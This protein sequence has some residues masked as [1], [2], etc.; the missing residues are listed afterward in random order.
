MSQDLV[1]RQ[2][3][4]GVEAIQNNDHFELR[5]PILDAGGTMSKSLQRK[6]NYLWLSCELIQDFCQLCECNPS[7]VPERPSES[8]RNREDILFVSSERSC[9]SVTT[10]ISVDLNIVHDTH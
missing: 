8:T 10:H 6:D 1:T 7:R 2:E 4:H 3:P 5:H 9:K